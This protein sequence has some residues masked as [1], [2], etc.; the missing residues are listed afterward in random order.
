MN[1]SGKKDYQICMYIDS[2]YSC[3]VLN[4]DGRK[5]AGIFR[6]KFT[7][8]LKLHIWCMHARK[9]RPVDLV[10]CYVST[11]CKILNL[12]QLQGVILR[13]RRYVPSP[14]NDTF[15]LAQEATDNNIIKPGK[16]GTVAI[17][18]LVCHF[19][20]VAVIDRSI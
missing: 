11:V 6:E 9:C 7:K 14:S 2:M 1:I 4:R 13:S 17:N 20:R 10:N 16:E 8:N 18:G 19:A 5:Y 12:L 15:E 3:N